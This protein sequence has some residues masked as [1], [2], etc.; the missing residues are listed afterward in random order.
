MKYGR[1]QDEF[2]WLEKGDF[3]LLKMSY[4]KAISE[5]KE[6]FKIPISGFDGSP[7]YKHHLQKFVTD[8]GLTYE[9]DGTHF[10]FHI[11]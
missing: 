4:D 8:K 2:D 1:S 10:I 5:Q 7:E 9:S 3:L 11:S 6:S